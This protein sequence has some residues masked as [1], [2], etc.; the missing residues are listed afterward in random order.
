M[1][2]SKQRASFGARLRYAIDNFM[3]RG[4]LSVFLALISLFAI[5]YAAMALLRLLGG[6]IWPDENLQ[7]LNDQLWRTFLQISD[8]G[9]VAEDGDA[10]AL[11]KFWGIATVSL[12]LVLFSSLVAFITQ[13][14]EARLQ[15]LRKGK[16]AVLESGHTLILGFRD[17]SVEVIRELI[18]ANE[19]ERDAAIGVLAEADKETMDDYFAEHIE[20]RKSTRIITRSGSTT[21]IDSLRKMAVGEAR[22]VVVLNEAGSS[23][24]RDARANGDARVLKAILAILAACDNVA[25]PIA[26]E[27]HLDRNRKLAEALAPGR[28]VAI[29]EDLILARLLV[30]TSRTS[31]LA[32]VYQNLVGFEGCEFYFYRH[33]GGW[34]GR[35]FDL[36]QLAFPACALLG[37]RDVQGKIHLNPPASYKPVDGEEAIVLAEDDSTIRCLDAGP[38]LAPALLPQGRRELKPEKQL[39]V[40]WNS[41]TP[42]II[43]EYADYASPGSEI[44]VVVAQ[45]TQTIKSAVDALR[46]SR[47]NLSIKLIQADVHSPDILAR[48]QPESYDNALLLAGDGESA[49]EVD[50]D[51][52]AILLQF[53]QHFRQTTAQNGREPDTKLITEVM[54]SENIELVLQ[55]GVRDFLI[56][57]QFVSRIVAQV[58]QEPDVMAIYDDLFSADG[59]EVYL[60]PASL[61]FGN[62]PARLSYA[63]C[64]VQARARNET[65]IGI[66]L[67]G[68]EQSPENNFGVRLI[69]P[70]DETFDLG[71]DDMLITLAEDEQ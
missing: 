34:G 20:D 70:Q 64:I 8:A 9:A 28:I 68:A 11:N 48:L 51:S 71:P 69:P 67:G 55:T 44:H 7:A 30:Q 53:R 12:G 42:L 56:S 61:F 25:P 3:A 31:G 47:S 19:S 33:A 43:G 29:H 16:S 57:N 38:A 60:K 4:G 40:G 22:G 27:L 39:L 46:E 6:L 24:A 21:S 13:Q 32:V 52:I 41:K 35:S 49:E 23:A 62:L 45:P 37:F 26:A 50:A 2:S 18:I 14:F 15:E 66:R 63:Q 65:L 58:S 1:S 54:D 36:L 10:N 59:A 5:A 17:R